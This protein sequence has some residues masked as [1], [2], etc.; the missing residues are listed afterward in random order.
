MCRKD[1]TFATDIFNYVV[2]S[3]ALTRDANESNTDKIA[4]ANLTGLPTGCCSAVN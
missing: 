4:A 1:V 2:C 3:A